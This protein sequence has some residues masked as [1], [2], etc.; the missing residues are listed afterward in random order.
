[1]LN[2]ANIAFLLDWRQSLALMNRSPAHL[3]FGGVLWLTSRFDER[4]HPRQVTP[5]C[6]R[7]LFMTFLRHLIVFI[8][9]N[10]FLF[11]YAAI[12]MPRETKR[13]IVFIGT[14]LALK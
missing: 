12:Q 8:E 3:P 1:M 13:S 6:D 10:S 7:F 14:R 2:S 4:F 5:R 11:S 9:S